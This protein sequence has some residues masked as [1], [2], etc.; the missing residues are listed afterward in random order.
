MIYRA[1]HE[2]FFERYTDVSWPLFQSYIIF[3]RRLSPFCVASTRCL[4]VSRTVRCKLFFLKSTVCL[5]EWHCI[6]NSFSAGKCDG[7]I[8]VTARRTCNHSASDAPPSL[9]RGE[10][11]G[12]VS[13]ADP[14]HW[15]QQLLGGLETSNAGLQ[16]DLLAGAHGAISCARHFSLRTYLAAR[17][18]GCRSSPGAAFNTQRWREGEREGSQQ[19]A[20]SKGLYQLSQ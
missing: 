15:K 8:N 5:E 19:R 6:V 7:E 17:L 3:I 13:V 10:E 20:A 18:P 9:W 12:S 16:I 1:L 2:H 4:Y 14:C 11:V